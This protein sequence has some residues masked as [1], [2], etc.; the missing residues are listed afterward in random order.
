[1]TRTEAS[2]IC[3][4]VVVGGG[5]DVVGAGGAVGMDVGTYGVAETSVEPD[6]V[7]AAAV[8]VTARMAAP[9]R[10]EDLIGW[11]GT[12]SMETPTSDLI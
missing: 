12:C 5:R 4:V 11:Q 1:M 8:S 10:C 6:D 2:G 9:R 3:M 7:Q